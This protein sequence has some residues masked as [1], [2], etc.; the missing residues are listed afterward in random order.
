MNKAGRRTFIRS[1]LG[2]AAGGLF[3]PRSL[4]QLTRATGGAVPAPCAPGAWR[5][6]GVVLTDHLLEH[7]THELVFVMGVLDM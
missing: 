1:T 6:H 5:K 4:A 7:R 2:L 3:V